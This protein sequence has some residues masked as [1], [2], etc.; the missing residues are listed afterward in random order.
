M[1][2]TPPRGPGPGSK[3]P[4]SA[5]ASASTSASP[6]LAS[7]A[8]SAAGLAA[9]ILF[10]GRLS[11]F[12]PASI[13]V[14][15]FAS[16][17][18]LDVPRESLCYA[19]LLVLPILGGFA[20]AA[21]WRRRPERP[22]P[23]SAGA[24]VN[25]GADAPDPAADLPPGFSP[26]AVGAHAITVWIFVV[27]AFPAFALR[28]PGVLFLVAAAASTVFALVLGR[29]EVREGAL[30]L[31]AAAAVLPLALL[32]PRPIPFASAAAGGAFALPAIACALGGR[33]RPAAV[34]LR[35][36]TLTVLIPGSLTATAGA[37]FLGVP[38]VADLFENGH[39]LLPASEYLRGERPYADVVPGH[40]VLS[41]GGLDA[42]SMRLLGDDYRGYVRGWKLLGAS[43]WPAIYAVGLGATGNPM[44]GLGVGLLSLAGFFQYTFLRV[45]PSLA[46]LALV[47]AASR[48]GRRRVW[49]AAGAA[50]GVSFFV[51]VDF[52][53]YAAG[54]AAAALWVSRGERRAA[55]ASFLR[56]AAGVGALGLAAMLALGVFPEFVDVTF[57]LV[58]SLLPV[59]AHGF[60]SA[61]PLGPASPAMLYACAGLGVLLL[62]ALLPRGPRVPDPARPLVPVCAWIAL[63]MLAVMERHHFNYPY[64]V[65]PAAVV[66]LARWIRRSA[67]DRLAG[68]LASVA[69]VAAFALDH[70]A[71]TLPAVTG[72]AI[73]PRT[74]EANAAPLAAPRRARGAL[75]RRPERVLIARTVEMMERA[76]FRDD[77]TWLDFA[78]EPGLYFLFDRR[79]PIRYY[80][81]AFYE[82]ESAQREVIAAVRRNPQVRAVLMSGTY[83]LI[84]GVSNEIRAPF[85]ARYIREN[86]RPFLR[87]DGIEFWIR[88]DGSASRAAT[89][90]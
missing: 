36:V 29:G 54:A 89:G 88:R 41:D 66:L 51:S 56:G 65:V 42:I 85:V 74:Y 76:G 52:A 16:R 40:G 28:S 90:P 20:A 87:E 39:E 70:G 2:A 6:R 8:G 18:A 68:S 47:L 78:N 24:A 72:V 12:L 62:G 55:L 59:Y 14:P 27:S 35:T 57:R 32:G 63:A 77:D 21:P 19:L 5:S 23:G 26:A 10:G 75:F 33:R 81:V 61:F 82:S 34:A 44:I 49:A 25:P 13:P 7:L 22:T 17:H 71:L 83:P 46:V 53:F 43:F 80:E 73:Q 48:T 58:P 86:F 38:P 9:A 45:V 50:L 60:P 79:C 3:A 37:A 15:G 30:Y 11:A 4:L 67:P 31:G 69:I 84:D 64:F 1:S